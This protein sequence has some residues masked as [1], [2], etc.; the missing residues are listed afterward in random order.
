M[1]KITVIF[2]TKSNFKKEVMF[3][4]SNLEI[5]EHQVEEYIKGYNEIEAWF[6]NTIQDP[7]QSAYYDVCTGL[8]TLRFEV[9]A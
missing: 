4:C 8:L 9:L 1:E 3:E 6:S 7:I 5:L 2:I